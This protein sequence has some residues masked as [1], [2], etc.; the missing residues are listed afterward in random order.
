MQREQERKIN[1]P[2]NNNLGGA[3]GREGKC[4]KRGHQRIYF[5]AMVLETAPGFTD[6][7]ET[8]LRI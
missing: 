7:I 6:K 8:V 2:P 3:V 5:T 4:G 1:E